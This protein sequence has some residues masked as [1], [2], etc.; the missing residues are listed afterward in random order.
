MKALLVALALCIAASRGH[1]ATVDIVVRNQPGTSDWYLE[2]NS[3]SGAQVGVIALVVSD[4]LGRFSQLLPPSPNPPICILIVGGCLPELPAAPPGYHAFQF[5]L[6]STYPLIP[7]SGVVG[8]FTQT[9]L[10][11]PVE[12]LPGDELFGAT[13]ASPTFDILDYS[14]T[15]VPEPGPSALLLVAL[16]GVTRRLARR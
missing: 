2:V 7:F 12:V 4:A 5:S 14:I 1:A 10:P 11:L 3:L 15:V 9:N 6:G 8:V 13:A 16:A